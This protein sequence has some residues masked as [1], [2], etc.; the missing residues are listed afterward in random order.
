MNRYLADEHEENLLNTR[1]AQL[2]GKNRNQRNRNDGDYPAAPAITNPT[3]KPKP[4]PKAK[5][6]GG[7]GGGG[8][9]GGGGKGAGAGTQ[10]PPAP[11]KGDNAQRPVVKSGKP[12]YY[13]QNKLINQGED[14]R[15]GKVNCPHDHGAPMSKEDFA[16]I[17]VPRKGSRSPS[18]GKRK[19]GGTGKGKT[20]ERPL[21]RKLDSGVFEPRYC[22]TFYNTGKCNWEKD[23][24]GKTCNIPHLD[25]KQY[26]DR[27][28][29]YNP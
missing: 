5:G 18:A 13:H 2:T 22:S 6:G 3:P 9:K 1:K 20:G 21:W 23:N 14:C 24:P 15:K 26:T 25:K 28:K 27:Y 7:G 19:T 17:P 16:K 29:E 10:A 8:G 11:L 12:C 4:K